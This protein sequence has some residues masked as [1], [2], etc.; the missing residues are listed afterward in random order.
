M[1]AML[2]SAL[3]EAG[4]NAPDSRVFI[5]CFEVGPLERL[6]GMTEL[7]LVQLVASRGGPADRDIAYAAMLDADGL[8]AIGR[9]ADALGPEVALV[10]GEDGASTGLAERARAAG[11]EVHAWTARRENAFLPPR[12]RRG[13][14]P[15]EPGDFPALLEGLRGAGVTGVFT[16]HPGEARRV[17]GEAPASR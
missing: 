16:D 6:A 9:Y 15:A 11:L 10:L 17:F 3:D 7:P 14:D 12:L 1:A 2:V 13:P 4:L 5:Q 8:R